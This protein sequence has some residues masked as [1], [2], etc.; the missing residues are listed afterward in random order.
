MAHVIHISSYPLGCIHLGK[1]GHL[2]SLVGEVG[3]SH[4][5]TN[6]CMIDI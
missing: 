6:N 3:G 5:A 4:V 2:A 1:C